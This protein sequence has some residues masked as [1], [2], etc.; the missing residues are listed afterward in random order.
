MEAGWSSG[1]TI[2]W[3]SFGAG[4]QCCRAGQECAVGFAT[5]ATA[6][7]YFRFTRHSIILKKAVWA[8]CCTTV[9]GFWGA[10][11]LSCHAGRM[12]TDRCSTVLATIGLCFCCEGLSVTLV[13][14]SIVSTVWFYICFVRVLLTPMREFIA[15]TA[16]RYSFFRSPFSHIDDDIHRS[17]S[18]AV[19]GLLEVLHLYGFKKFE[20]CCCLSVAVFIGLFLLYFR[21]FSET[22]AIQGV[23][24]K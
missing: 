21:I 1:N 19:G 17:G 12:S 5:L 24:K 18:I 16:G 4:E 6:S 20:C 11:E 15:A 14:A 23:A 13:G 10:E 22:V 2:V 3:D 9:R 7:S 8:N